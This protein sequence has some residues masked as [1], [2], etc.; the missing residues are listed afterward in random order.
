MGPGGWPPTASATPRPTPWASRATRPRSPSTSTTTTGTTTATTTTATTT[1]TTTTATSR[2]RAAV[3]AIIDN[4]PPTAIAVGGVS[5]RECNR[6][7]TLLAFTVI[8][9]AA[10]EKGVSVKFDTANG[11][12]TTADN[13]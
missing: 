6:G 2:G 10:S 12:A 4:D 1:T 9:S 3:G 8:L 13:D 11:T 5:I 7:T